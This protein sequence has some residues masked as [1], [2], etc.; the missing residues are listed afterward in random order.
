LMCC[1]LFVAHFMRS[2]EQ[3]GAAETKAFWS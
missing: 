3:L 2:P 1:R